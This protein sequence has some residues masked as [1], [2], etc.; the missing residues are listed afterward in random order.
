MFGKTSV[1]AAGA[2][3][4]AGSDKGEADTSAAEAP[5][6]EGEATGLD[7]VAEPAV[8][9][10]GDVG[11]V[12]AA[13]EPYAAAPGLL[14]PAGLGDKVGVVSTSEGLGT[15]V[16]TLNATAV[17]DAVPTGVVAGAEVAAGEAA[18]GT[19]EVAGRG[20]MLA[21]GSAVAAAVPE[22]EETNT[23]A[24]MVAVVAAGV[25]LA[26]EDSAIGGG[27]EDKNGGGD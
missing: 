10:V 20:D 25:G 9:A 24:N 12:T 14:L 13:G 8:T 26:G 11:A 21:L 1:G 6:C 3:G 15:A 7:G 18:I 16:G 4:T 2:A 17:C 5:G 19:G 23:G 22:G 27:G